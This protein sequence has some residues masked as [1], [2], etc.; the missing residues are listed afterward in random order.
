MKAG[1][2][3]VGTP[4]SIPEDKE[5]S[6]RTFSNPVKSIYKATA[7][8]TFGGETLRMFSLKSLCS[9]EQIK[10]A[11]VTASIQWCMRQLSQRSV[12]G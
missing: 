11:P 6:E 5:G 3:G 9:Q 7:T 8:I 10:D 12:T 1:P 2:H 4:T